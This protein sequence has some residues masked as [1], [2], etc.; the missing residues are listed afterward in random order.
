MARILIALIHAY[1]W[2]ISPLFPPRCR[3]EPTC[4]RYAIHA[5]ENHGLLRGSWFIVKRL[6]RCHPYEKIVKQIGP[7]FGYDPVPLSYK[8]PANKI[9]KTT[10]SSSH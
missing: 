7:T 3:F 6:V 9:V 2:V 5:L 4:S 10:S 8:M 1:R